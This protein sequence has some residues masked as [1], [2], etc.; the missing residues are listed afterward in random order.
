MELELLKEDKKILENLAVQFGDNF[1]KGCNE[2]K[3]IIGLYGI[4]KKTL[5]FFKNEIKNYLQKKGKDVL[6]VFGE[7]FYN[8]DVGFFLRAGFFEGINKEY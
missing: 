1:L 7:G 4:D 3:R 8:I 2:N 5:D 6:V